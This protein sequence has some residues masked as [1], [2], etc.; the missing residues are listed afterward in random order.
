[1]DR[2][3]RVALFGAT[4]RTGKETL[5]RALQE[6][7]S[8]SALVR[9]PALL[10]PDAAPCRVVRG[11]ALRRADVSEA[12]RGQ[13]AVIVAL[14]TRGDIGPTTVLS[15][16]TRNIVAAMKEHGVRKVV[17]CLSAFLLWDPDKVPVRLR[18]LTE[19]HARMH[20]VLSEAGLQ[21]VAVM[22]PH[23][24]DDKPLTEAYKVTV[25]GTGGG[26]RVISTPDLAHFLVRCLSTTEFDG[27][28]VYVCGHYG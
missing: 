20:A 17:A 21:Y 1:M 11:D 28:S 12:V 23:I 9:N 18:A 13:R 10:P 2:D 26:S 7:F 4:G 27:K 14:G 15:D 25:G 6:G 24:A 16:S 3:R 5:K 19:D 22:P 8:V